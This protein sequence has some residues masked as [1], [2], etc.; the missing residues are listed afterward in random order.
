MQKK[1]ALITLIVIV[2]TTS[3][4]MVLALSGCTGKIAE[5]AIEKAIEKSIEKEG[6]D[7]DLDL[8]E[9]EVN[10]T[11]E[12]GNVMNLGGSDIPEDWPQV[13]PVKDGIT[14][15]FSASQ[16]T[17]GKKN[18][19]LTGTYSGSGEELYDYYKNT[20]SGWNQEYDS[21]TDSGTEGKNY[22][23]QVNN[24]TYIATVIINETEDEVN[25]VLAINEK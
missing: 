8:S 1:S 4:F 25:V 21:V 11:D 9:N 3:L 18:F 19:S 10:I 5:K 24:D 14:P 13:L 23:Y 7:I 17:D 6:G 22:S 15:L 12:E 20:L 2:I 16:T